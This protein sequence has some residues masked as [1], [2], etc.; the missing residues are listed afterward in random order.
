MDNFLSLYF[1]SIKFQYGFTTY[2]YVR[3]FEQVYH[4]KTNQSIS[5]PQSVKPLTRSK[6]VAKAKFVPNHQSSGNGHEKIHVLPF[7]TFA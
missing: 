5:F 1:N 7:V 4:Y 2:D 3:S 6:G